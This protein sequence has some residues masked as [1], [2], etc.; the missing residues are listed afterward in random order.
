MRA[1]CAAHLPSALHMLVDSTN[2]ARRHLRRPVTHAPAAYHQ[3]IPPR[4]DRNDRRRARPSPQDPSG[5]AE[6]LRLSRSKGL[7]KA[8]QKSAWR[9]PR[10]RGRREW[11]ACVN[12]LSRQSKMRDRG[13]SGGG[14]YLP[15]SIRRAIISSNLLAILSITQVETRPQHRQPRK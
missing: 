6:T 9:C 5:R 2:A 11:A 14:S 4:V 10:Q 7:P 1:V 8:M 12:S 13:R 15:R 3:R